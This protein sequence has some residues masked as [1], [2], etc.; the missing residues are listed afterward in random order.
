MTQPPVSVF[1]GPPARARRA[2]PTRTR[3]VLTALLAMLL[4][5]VGAPAA[6]QAADAGVPNP[7]ARGPL[8]TDKIDY[9]AGTLQA[10]L[11]DGVTTTNLPLR[12]SI[13]YPLTSEPSKLIVFLHGRH[14]VCFTGGAPAPGSYVCDDTTAPDGTPTSTNIRSYGGYDYLA[15]NLATHG[16]AVASIEANVSN[17]DNNYPDAGAS[18]RSQMIQAHLRL[19]T[20]WKYGTGP[21][22][23]DP[24]TTI[25]N[26]LVGK[27]ELSSGIG[28]MGHSRGGDAVTDFVT[29]NQN[30]ASGVRNKIAGVVA[31]APT[32]YTLNRFPKGVNYAT[33]L[34]TCDGDVSG[35]QGAKFFENAKYDAGNDKVAK[36]Q[37]AVEGTNHN[38][39]NSTWTGDDFG[40]ASDPSCH[41]EAAK[42]GR[43]SAV[44]QRKVG[45]A[46][47]NGFMRRYV[48]GERAFDPLMTGEVTLP[49]SLGLTSGI[50]AEKVVKTSYVGPKAGR[51]DV[52]STTPANDPT[53]AAQVQSP[54]VPEDLTETDLGGTL[55]ASGLAD[56]SVCKPLSVPR[57]GLAAEPSSYPVCP[58]P[59]LPAG[60][61]V[62]AAG[63]RSIGTQYTVAWD[64]PSTLTAAL[65]AGGATQ[66]V[67]R[68]GVL[69]L[70]V[71]VNRFDARNPATDG[72]TAGQGAQDFDVTLIDATGKRSTTGAGEWGEA[73]D[74]SIG[75]RY[76]HVLLGGLRI[77]MSAFKGVDLTQVTAVEF[78]FGART[79]SGSIQLNDVMFQETAKPVIE[80]PAPAAPDGPPS[81]EGVIIAP[82][83]PA[84]APVAQCTVDSLAPK[85]RTT[86]VS[87]K[88]GVVRIK[89]RASDVACAGITP[90]G[91]GATL[92]QITRK[93]SGGKL[94]YV[95]ANGNLS[96]PRTAAKA[97][98][99]KASGRT[100][101]L[102]TL[103][104]AKLPK[105]TYTVTIT[106]VDQAGNAAAPIVRRVRVK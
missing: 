48:G 4:A 31:L 74:P 86:G 79:A 5:L 81:P 20:R 19:L 63:N 103:K 51:L 30:L 13:R 18:I 82:I 71:A 36:I 6:T 101:W 40:T 42:T 88:R 1:A 52:L 84:P 75:T 77:P 76:P 23:G 56:F 78:G 16:Y 15:E 28:L 87:V 67:S 102:L 29:Y 64:G 90:S 57:R 7:L 10:T 38:F 94:R 39:Y 85:T 98:A 44:D 9:E 97:I 3:S 35:L 89:G 58:S 34:P 46:L 96:K 24:S 59:S 62:Y 83:V 53:E 73:L 45:V 104:K 17:F 95:T 33:L 50:D 49:E 80:E 14:S 106:T 25:G 92:I 41:T 60:P 26:K 47:M 21:V 12:G 68:F 105:G 65:G 91:T 43:L 37:W 66:D 8:Q 99:L 72:F 70:R 100:S 93:A 27:L 55:T 69:D 11:G 54:V 2:T 61:G 32:Y 22:T